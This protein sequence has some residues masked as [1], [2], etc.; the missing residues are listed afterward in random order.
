VRL[1]PIRHSLAIA[2]SYSMH[3]D[4]APARF[5]VASYGNDADQCTFGSPCKTFQHAVD[6]ADADDEVTA[7]DGADYGPI[8]I[9]KAV[10][11]ETGNCKV[12][13][14]GSMFSR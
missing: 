1:K 4:P 5:F 8:T 6:V 10:P 13:P 9:T 14:Q 2:F 11:F 3:A 12:G 7:L